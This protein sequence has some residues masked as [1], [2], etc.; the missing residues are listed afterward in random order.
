MGVRHF[1][2]GNDL[3]ILSRFWKRNGEALREMIGQS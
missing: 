1:G 2:V 3:T